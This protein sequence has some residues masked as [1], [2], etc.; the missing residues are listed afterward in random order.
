MAAL[1]AAVEL[2]K[3]FS[4]VPSLL[5]P[6][7]HGG[8]QPTAEGAPWLDLAEVRIPNR[9]LIQPYQ[10]NYCCLNYMPVWT[11][12]TARGCPHRCKF[13]SVWQFYKNRELIQ[14]Y[15]K[16][17]CCLNYMPVWTMETARGCPHRHVVQ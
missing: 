7:G 11:M 14:P 12:E 1:C 6:D 8:F 17:Y 13:C 16:N 2:G 10:K 5:L 3:P 15:Q 9:E 4:D